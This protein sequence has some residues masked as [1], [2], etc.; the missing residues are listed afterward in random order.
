MRLNHSESPIP[1]TPCVNQPTSASSDGRGYIKE[2]LGE[3]TSITETETALTHTSMKNTLLLI[4]TAAALLPLA[5]GGIL[6]TISWNVTNVPQNGLTDITFPFSIANS[7]HKTGYYFAQQFNFNGQSDI[8]YTGL[9]PRPDS[10]S[11]PVI[12][13]VFSSFI[14]DSTTTDGN[15]H[16]GADGGA[17]VSCSVEFSGPYENAYQL[18]I[19]NTKDTTWNGTVVDATTGRRVHVGSYTL[20][21]G[22]QGIKGSQVGFVEYYPWNTGSHTCASLP[23]TSMVFGVP[24]STTGA[25]GSLGNAYEYGDCVGKVAYKSSRIAAG[26]EVSVGF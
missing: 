7:P 15:C 12:H 21:A 3:T 23:Y 9:Q 4:T 20:P 2:T 10:N 18:E 6:N 22:T 24:T 1:S 5:M 14:K 16:N 8:G 17:G 11:N 19:R 13:A 26:V 25:I